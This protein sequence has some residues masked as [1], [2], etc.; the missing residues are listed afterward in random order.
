VENDKTRSHAS[1]FTSAKQTSE[2]WE[3]SGDPES[4]V[5]A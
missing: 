5:P 3:I 2:L 4:E 1:S